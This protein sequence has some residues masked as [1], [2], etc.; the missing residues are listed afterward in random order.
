MVT[1]LKKS[2]VIKSI[3]NKALKFRIL[4]LRKNTAIGLI[5]LLYKLI[6]HY[7]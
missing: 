7:T 6:A 4:Y 2:Q 5:N 3:I 1:L